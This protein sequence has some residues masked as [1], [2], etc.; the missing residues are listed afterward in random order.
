[1]AALKPFGDYQNPGVYKNDLVWS[2]ALEFFGDWPVYANVLPRKDLT[3]W[4][5]FARLP[6]AD[7]ERINKV[8]REHVLRVGSTF[9]FMTYAVLMYT[10]LGADHAAVHGQYVYEIALHLLKMLQKQVGTAFLHCERPTILSG[11]FA[12]RPQVG[13]DDD[14]PGNAAIQRHNLTVINCVLE[15]F[16]LYYSVCLTPLRGVERCTP[17]HPRATVRL[18]PEGYAAANRSFDQGGMLLILGY[19]D[20]RPAAKSVARSA[21]NLAAM[22]RV[23]IM[24]AMMRLLTPCHVGVLCRYIQ[25][26]LQCAWGW[27]GAGLS[28]SRLGW[29]HCGPWERCTV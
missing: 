25:R 7:R 17:L 29:R 16:E 24:C 9:G 1:M 3:K 27:S 13:E 20:I 14:T 4:R 22:Q 5:E 26:F 6:T 18:T 21:L 10:V 28:I 23:S 11:W 2:Q 15:Y 19:N 12:C 8:R